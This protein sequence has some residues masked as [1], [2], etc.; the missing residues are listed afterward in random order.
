VLTK[1]QT[2][3][4]SP[5]LPLQYGYKDWVPTQSY[6]AFAYQVGCAPKTA[7]GNNSQTV[8]QCLQ[9][10]DTQTL[11]A[12]SANVSASGIFGTWGFLPVTDGTL[13]QQ[14]PSQQLLQK[15]VNGQRLLIGGNVN[16]GT[17]FVSQ[18]IRTEDDL[19]AWLRLSFPLFT[20][21]DIAKVLLYYPSSNASVDPNALLYAT[22]GYTGAT[23]LNES[24]VGTGQQQRADNIY[25]ETTFDCPGYWMAEAY[26]DRG[27]ISYKYQYSVPVSLHGAD[28]SGFFGPATPNQGSDFEYAFMKI[29]GNFITQNNPSIS[30]AV[31]NGISVNSSATSA[32]P[33]S[34]WPPYTIYAPYQLN[35]NESGGTRYSF[36]TQTGVNATQFEQPGLQN[37]FTLANAYTWEG[38]RGYR[39]DF[40]RSM[41]VLAPE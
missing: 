38:G 39:C 3:A 37:N 28:V 9:A 20:N 23:A 34:N 6:F 16:E 8:F 13:I 18:N 41:G 22:N 14:R 11:I 4:S 32:N 19:V 25:A 10:K 26:S 17:Y 35:L 1:A 30:D 5:Y 29:V 27:R 31:A 12:A 7:Y 21:D 40:W 15:K 36:N 24:Q 2:F 33:A